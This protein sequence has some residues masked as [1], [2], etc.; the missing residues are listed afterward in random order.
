MES[1]PLGILVLL[2]AEELENLKQTQQE[3]LAL[4]KDL[5][6]VNAERIQAKYIT[7][8]EFMKA[9]QICRSKFDLL[10]QKNKIK[11]LKKGRKIYV[12]I[13]EIDRYFSDESIP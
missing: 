9:I 11:T 12:P 4:V 3:I 10:V 7:A 6:S 8:I 5:K 2:P 1:K 13:A